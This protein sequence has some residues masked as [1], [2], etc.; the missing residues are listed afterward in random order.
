MKS[1]RIFSY[2]LSLSTKNI[3]MVKRFII[4][5]LLGF[6]LE[7]LWTGFNSLLK[8][9]IKLTGWTYIWMFPVY[10][11]AVFL[12]VVHDRIRYLPIIVRGGIYT[13]LIFG[14]EYGSGL[15]FRSI[16]GVC[17]WNY[18]DGPLSIDGLITLKYI[19]VWFIVGL[20]FEK[21]HDTLISI[22]HS[23]H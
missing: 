4:Y 5:G 17:P 15:L 6:C 14:A 16:L 8:G 3:L 10:G 13:V 20:L 19:P 9:D 2:I 21:M 22:E 23:I 7:V 11:L 18:G 12:E 1:C